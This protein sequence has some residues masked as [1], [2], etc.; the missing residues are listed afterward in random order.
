M[1]RKERI[2]FTGKVIVPVPEKPTDYQRNVSQLATADFITANC[3]CSRPALDLVHGFDE[4]FPSAWREDSALEFELFKHQVPIVKLDNAKV[5]HPV[6]KAPWGV[7]IRDQKKSMF[8]AL[9][10][11][12]YPDFYRKKIASHPVWSYYLIIILSLA[13]II[14]FTLGHLA[15]GFV[16]IGMWGLFIAKFIYKRLKGTVMS[17][18]H[19]MEMIVT[20]LFIPYLSVFWTLCGAIRYKVFFL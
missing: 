19:G 7:S 12:K 15:A 5:I 8:N 4:A 2:S 14:L 10:F 16:T 18:S 17:F 6:R 11:K 20:S 13:A 1:N 3:A 9:L